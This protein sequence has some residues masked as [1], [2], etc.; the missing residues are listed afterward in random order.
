MSRSLHFFTTP[1]NSLSFCCFV[2]PVLLSSCGALHLTQRTVKTAVFKASVSFQDGVDGRG[3]GNFFL[4]R[5]LFFLC[6]SSLF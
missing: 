3:N 5:S 1:H 2:C 6:N 4:S